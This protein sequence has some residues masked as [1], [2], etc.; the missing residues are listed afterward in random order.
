MKEKGFILSFMLVLFSTGVFADPFTSFK[1]SNFSAKVLP[2]AVDKTENKGKEFY[3]EW[4]SFV[5]RLDNGY[6]AYTRFEIANLGPGDGKLKVRAKFRGPN[7]KKLVS[8][9]SFSRSQWKSGKNSLISADGNEIIYKDQTFYL[10]LNNKKFKANLT[11]KP[12]FKPWRP[13]NGRINYGDNDFYYYIDVPLPLGQVDGDFILSDGSKHHVTG[14]VYMDHQRS[15]AGMHKTVLNVF[16][17]RKIGKDRIVFLFV[18][19]PPR[20]YGD[21]PAS[22]LMALGPDFKVQALNLKIK[23]L[24]FWQDPQSNGY[25]VPSKLKF[26]GK[27]ADGSD[28]IGGVKTLKL[29]DR[30]D[31][32][33]S[34]STLERFI[35]SKFAKPI[36]YQ[37]DGKMM[38]LLKGK[39]SLKIKTSGDIYFTGVNH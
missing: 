24:A 29:T 32:L 23:R 11:F 33:A 8:V 22:F 34:L 35:V 1:G 38:L 27:T 16:R 30:D 6:W 37:F 9:R 13:G 7:I 4:W 31:F 26:S 15:N 10:K 28:I 12:V 25:K 14:M 36:D 18:L 2:P 39:K 21:S 19:Y 20:Q 17:F 5:F 3:S